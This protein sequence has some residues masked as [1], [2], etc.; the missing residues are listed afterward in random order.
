MST[1]ELVRAL[2]LPTR[3]ATRAKALL[4]DALQ[5][6]LTEYNT[7]HTTERH[8]RFEDV[9]HSGPHRHQKLTRPKPVAAR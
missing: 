5:A 8:R 6:S 7:V 2:D 1:A 3:S 9:Q 4:Q